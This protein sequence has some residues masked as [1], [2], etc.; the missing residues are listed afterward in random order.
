[1]TRLLKSHRLIVAW[2]LLLTLALGLPS[3]AQS[4]AQLAPADTAVFIHI[5]KPAEWFGDL[6]QGPLG[7]KMREKIQTQEGS[8]D[9]LAALGMNLD[10]FMQAYFGGD[11]VVLSEGGDGAPGVIFTEVTEAN[12]NHAID[13]LALERNGE[14][15]GFPQ[16]IGPDGNGIFVMMDKWVAL[17]DLNSAKLL[18]D[19][20][21][22]APGAPRLADTEFYKKWTRELPADRSMTMLVNESE[23]SQHALGV[24]RQGKGLDATYLGTSPDFDELMGMLGE[25]TVAEF[26]PLPTDTIAAL[27]FNLVANEEMSQQLAGLDP[28]LRGKSFVK[29][30]MPKLDPP[31]LL[32]MGSV[33]GDAV[34]PKVSVELPVM[35]LA[36][37]MND[38]TVAADLKGMIDGLMLIANFAVAEFKAGPVPQRSET[39]KGSSFQV[40][41][42]GKSIAIGIEFP[43]IAP[44]QIVY[45]QVGDYFIIC[46][47]EVFFKQCVDANA[48]G[49][50]M[51]IAVEGPAH[52]LA[53][54][55]ELA[56]TAR[57]DKFG[58]LMLSWVKM[59]DEKG[60]PDAL[61]G[62][63]EQPVDTETLMD[64]VQ[65]F[66]QYSLMKMQVWTGEDGLVIGRAQLTP[67]Q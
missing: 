31:T 28:L 26:G 8:G 38:D 25:T 18:T 66:Q 7:E 30:I 58:P 37:K 3:A 60:L 52:R 32:F 63:G 19:I 12:R 6:T 24:V 35:G 40:A 67:P 14:I 41:E 45:G 48:G 21:S 11:V 44:M 34:D 61:A 2:A 23:D 55:P 9:L 64:I 16:Y 65:M 4:P 43:E 10:Q 39:Y 29:D 27:S 50:A 62:E 57:P 59:L 56:M 22:Q 17:C 13:S 42:L 47:Q 1:M 51:R 49:K 46:T 53:Q 15:A 5:N 20:L 36:M 54:T 33:A